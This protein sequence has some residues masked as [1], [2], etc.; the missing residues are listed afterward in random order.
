MK[1]RVIVV[2]DH[3]V[4]SDGLRQLIDKQ[5]DLACVGIADNTSDAKRL[6][7]QSKPASDA[8]RS[9]LERRRRA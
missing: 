8:S 9:A 7:E 5:P 4:L 3:P 6:V 1:S 2:E